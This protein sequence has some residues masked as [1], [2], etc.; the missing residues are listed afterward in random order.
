MREKECAGLTLLVS[1]EGA[2]HHP[3]YIPLWFGIA[4][5]LREGG[6]GF[7]IALQILKSR[8]EGLVQ[9]LEL[10]RD[11]LSC[12][13]MLHM[14]DSLCCLSGISKLRRKSAKSLPVWHASTPGATSMLELGFPI[15]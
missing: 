14:R 2:T 13:I 10:K 3:S 11:V 12:S 9:G 5:G 1:F 7:K 4:S 15:S 6:L 8:N